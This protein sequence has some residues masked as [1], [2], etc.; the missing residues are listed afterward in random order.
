M[1]QQSNVRSC[2]GLHAKLQYGERL[3]ELVCGHRDHLA[4]ALHCSDIVCQCRSYGVGPQGTQDYPASR[5][6]LVGARGEASQLRG[7]QVGPALSD[8]QDCPSEI[9]L[10]G[11][12]KAKVSYRSK[13]SLK[14]MAVPGHAPLQNPLYQTLWAACQL[15][16]H[17]YYFSKQLFLPI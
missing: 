11:F 5:Q 6:C 14:G 10:N 8:G 17:S 9:R 13:L 3:D 7:T 1:Y 12:P 16:Y 15:A 2:H 4:G